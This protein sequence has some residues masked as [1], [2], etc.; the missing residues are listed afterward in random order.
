MWR[1]L[2]DFRREKQRGI[3]PRLWLSWFFWST[4]FKL[5]AQWARRDILMSRDKDCRKTSFLSQL[6]RNYPHRGGNLERGKNPLLWARDSLGGILGDDLGE[7][8]CESTIVSRQRGDKFCR[9][10]YQD[11]SQGPLDRGYSQEALKGDI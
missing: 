1:K 6:S 10:R 8:N 11:V 4:S 7:G 3:L 9:A 2:P 5:L